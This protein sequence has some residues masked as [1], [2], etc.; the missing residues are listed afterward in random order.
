MQRSKL[1]RP[2]RLLRGGGPVAAA[3]G[4]GLEE[5]PAAERPEPGHRPAGAAHG[6]RV[7]ELVAAAAAH[8][9]GAA[10]PRHRALAVVAPGQ[11]LHGGELVVVVHEPTA[12]PPADADRRRRHAAAADEVL[13]AVRLHRAPDE[14]IRHRRRRRRLPVRRRHRHRRL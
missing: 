6:G 1:N 11:H 13:R 8:V 4:A 12:R 10:E 9:H 7:P 3:G 5:R 14:V 2:P